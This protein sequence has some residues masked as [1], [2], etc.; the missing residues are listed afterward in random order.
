[1]GL[2]SFWEVPEGTKEPTF[3]PPLRL[4]GGM[5]SGHG[6]GSF[7]GK[8]YYSAIQEVSGVS[9]YQ[10][11]MEPG[12][13]KRIAD[14]LAAYEPTEEWLERHNILSMK[15][16]NDLVRMFRGYADVGASLLGWW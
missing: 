4:C 14:A 8:V 12:D 6:K 11:R 16:W 7:R 9:L 10:E 3:D 15:E 2:D 13:V 5:F 1:M